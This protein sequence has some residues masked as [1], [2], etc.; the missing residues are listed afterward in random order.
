M[1]AWE[2]MDI[3]EINWYGLKFSVPTFAI[4][5]AA[6]INYNRNNQTKADQ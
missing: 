1:K 3:L 5:F 6:T 2:E 4:N